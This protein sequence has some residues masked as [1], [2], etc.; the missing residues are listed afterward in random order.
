M[1]DMDG[2][3]IGACFFHENRILSDATEMMSSSRPNVYATSRLV[4][5]RSYRMNGPSETRACVRSP[6][7]AD[8]WPL[9]ATDLSPTGKL[10]RHD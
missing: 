2:V 5:K 4:R 9:S 7:R 1:P 8:I 3:A 10:S 6:L